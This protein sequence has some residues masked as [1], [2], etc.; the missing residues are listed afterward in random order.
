MAKSN[1]TSDKYDNNKSIFPLY[2]GFF[3]TNMSDVFLRALS[4]SMQFNIEL[5]NAFVN[6]YP[7][8]FNTISEYNKS[9]KDLSE[10]DKILRSRFRRSSMK[11]SGKKDS[12][13]HF[14]ILLPAIQS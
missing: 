1:F 8:Y 7:I 14:Q 9:W 13:T 3:M 10:L 6:A 4:S 2:D 12:S 11:S 5:Y